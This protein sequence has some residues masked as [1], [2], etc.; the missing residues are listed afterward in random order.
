MP[1]DTSGTYTKPPGTT[2][3]TGQI[4]SSSAYNNLANDEAAALTDSLSRSGK[5]GMQA[6]LSM[7]G[8]KVINLGAGSANS[9]ALRKD[10]ITALINATIAGV[11]SYAGVSS[12]PANAQTV[13]ITGV[14]AYESGQIFSF[15]AGAS[16]TGA[17]TLNV[18][19]LGAKP[20]V[21]VGDSLQAGD[22]L[23]GS[24]SLVIYND[25]GGSFLLLNPKTVGTAAYRDVGTGANNV[26]SVFDGS[27]NMNPAFNIANQ[28][29]DNLS[30]DGQRR[31]IWASVSFAGNGAIV[32]AFNG[33]GVARNSV[34]LYTVTFPTISGS[35]GVSIEM[36]VSVS[37]NGNN[38][39]VVSGSR[40][41]ASVQ[42]STMSGNSSMSAFD[43]DR[44]TVIIHRIG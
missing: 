25:T 5:G 17:A 30:A 42:I 43:P 34:G 15:I 16:N 22:I 12:G 33:A 18:N 14:Q 24:I 27:G 3:V 38:A 8:K 10:Q 44:V 21:K 19:G 6:D 11:S 7:G 28:G 39:N 9:D 13:S 40:G 2:A 23:S 32:A 31:T 4:I 36:D 26:M 29:L 35:Y 37:A 20:I 1:R 41:T